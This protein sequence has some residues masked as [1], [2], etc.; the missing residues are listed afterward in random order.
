MDRFLEMLPDR[1][2]ADR[3]GIIYETLIEDGKPSVEI[4]VGPV[5]TRALSGMRHAIAAMAA[6]GNNMIVDEVMTAEN[7]VWYRTLLAPYDMQMVAIMAPLEV[8][9]E[10]ERLRGDRLPGL[11]RRQ[12]GRIH[13]GIAY[14]FTVDTATASAL[15]CAHLIR[16]RFNL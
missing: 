7:A 1:G 13:Q 3:N 6:A 5:A 4:R 11:A 16:A 8:L 2:P 14:D 9:E 12:F 15:E 10:R